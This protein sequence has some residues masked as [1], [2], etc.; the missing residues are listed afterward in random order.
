MKI[1][2]CTCLIAA[3]GG[4]CAQTHVDIY[5]VVD[6]AGQYLSGHTHDVRVISGGLAASRLGF[7][8]MEELGDGV[9]AEFTLEGG[10]N[11][12]EGGSQQGGTLFG[13][14]AFLALHTPAGAVS[15]GRQYSSIFAATTD[16]SIFGN[17]GAGPTSAVIGGF[18]GGYEPVRGSSPAAVPPASGAGLNGG[19][20]RVNNSIRYGTP[21]WHGLSGSVLYGAGEVAGGT[22]QT[23]L[24]DV[25]ARYNADGLQLLLSFIDDKAAATSAAGPTDVTTATVAA[26]YD[27]HP[28]RVVGAY[29]RVDDKS[30]ANADGHGFWVGASYRLGA[31][32]LKVQF[33][34]NRPLKADSRTNAYGVGWQYDFS[35]RT[36]LYSSLT[37]FQNQSGAGVD[38]LGRLN[39]AV[40]PG[41][42]VAGDASVTE[43]VLGM[44]HLF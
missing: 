10:I 21:D 24:V 31:Q 19:P 17:T 16:F 25:G 8:G 40:P 27:M 22:N 39:S 34:Q 1:V 33:V 28:L 18:A 14:E 20:V 29:I 41:L 4:A 32:L 5:G 44:R 12:D 15:L 7:R 26:S 36:S 38:G 6:V 2:A 9:R 30:S 37:R 42:G 3:T 35:K 23:R 43:A 11:A 13:R